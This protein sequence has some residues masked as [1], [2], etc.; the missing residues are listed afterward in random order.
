MIRKVLVVT[1]EESSDFLT[2]IGLRLACF[3]DASGRGECHAGNLRTNTL[4]LIC[5]GFSLFRGERAGLE[6]GFWQFN[7]F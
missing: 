5:S 3:M 7:K 2:A 4:T 1:E 6:S